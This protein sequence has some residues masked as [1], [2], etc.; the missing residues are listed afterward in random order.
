VFTP[1]AGC[2]PG[3]TLNSTKETGVRTR[4]T[5]ASSLAQDGHSNN[6]DERMFKDNAPNRAIPYIYL[7]DDC[8]GKSLAGKDMPQHQQYRL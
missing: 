2:T 6:G 4:Q 1:P 7:Q 3:R 8:C 5:A